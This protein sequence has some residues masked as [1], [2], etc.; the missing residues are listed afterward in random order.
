MYRRALIVIKGFG[1]LFHK[2]RNS[3]NFFELIL[4]A[5]NFLKREGLNGIR[6]RLSTYGNIAAPEYQRWIDSYEGLDSSSK[7][8]IKLKIDELDSPPLISVLMP[9]FDSNIVWLKE[10]I[11]SVKKQL[12]PHWELCIADD[13][14]NNAEIKSFL[15]QCSQEDLR[16]KLILCHER[17][18]ISATTNA[19]LGI[20]TGQWIILLDHD[21]LISEDALYR[22]AMVID[23]NQSLRLIYSDEDRIDSL[24]VRFGAYFKGDWS[25]ELFYSQN[26][27]SHLGAYKK[28]LVDKIGGFR[29]GF[30]GSQDYDLALRCI[31]NITSTQIYHIPRILYHWRSHEK[32]FS[33]LNAVI[34]KNNGVRALNEHL[35]RKGISAQA[36]A[37]D[38]GYRIIY[39]PPQ[40]KPLVSLIIPTH[41]R[42]DLL[43]RAISSILEKTIYSNYELIIIDHQSNESESVSYLSEISSIKNIRIIRVVGSFNFSKFNN[44]AVNAANG[45]I[46][47]LL[48]ND[49]E[50]IT[51]NWLGEMVGL[52]IQEGAGAVGARLWYPNDTLQHGG[53][54]LGYGPSRIAGH[55]HGIQR[56]N[57]GYFGQAELI[58][59]FSAVTAACL[60][61]KKSVYFEADGLDENLPVDYNDVDFCLRL[62]RLGYRNIW[63]PYAELY[64]HEH[65]T[66]GKTLNPQR[67]T[68]LSLDI[69]YMQHRWGDSLIQDSFYNPNMSLDVAFR[70]SFPPRLKDKKIN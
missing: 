61:V 39:E 2:V 36:V 42:I 32:S 63:T 6:I 57:Q 17:Q 21:D 24:G 35:E 29:I 60:L 64:H 51:P 3:G 62:I 52:A 5:L 67:D 56:D 20:A 38:A 46:V 30:E 53:V 14:S 54:I 26:L 59:N 58:Q 4:R 55:I 23:S 25:P 33:H 65:G 66:R 70:L 18:G 48:N 9:T 45:S 10:A 16:I 27:I 7:A 12:Y 43:K 69:C 37:V 47:G 50:V 44:Q 1:I 19:A 22:V 11:A 15:Y 41:N 8:Y 68:Q 13:A 28:E 40:D 49:I 34:S 31:E